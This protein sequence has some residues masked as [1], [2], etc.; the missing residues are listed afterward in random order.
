[1]R[2]RAV[3]AALALGALAGSPAAAAPALTLAQA[4]AIAS[5]STS[6]VKLADLKTNEAQG[7]WDQSRAPLLPDISAAASSVNRTYSLKALGFNP[8]AVPGETAPA[9]LVGP[10]DVV[11]ARV[12][13]SQ[14]LF[15]Y[16]S[17]VRLRAAGENVRVAGAE[18][19]QSVEGAAQGAALAYLRAV[20]AQAVADARRADLAL[21]EQ[22]LTL[23]EEQRQAGVSPGIDVTRERTQVAASRGQL[24]MA[25]NALERARVDLARALGLDP[26]V[27]F[28]LADSLSADLAASPAPSDSAAALG[29]ALERRP[30][31]A[32]ERHKLSRARAEASAIGAERLPRLDVSGDVG[33]SGDSWEG[34]TT[35][36]E[37]AIAVSMPIFDGFRREG[38]IGEQR[39]LIEESEVRTRDLSRQVAAEVRAA[40]LDLAS[41]LEQQTV[42]IEGLALAQ[43]ELDEA[44][45]RF[46]SGVAGN[47]EVITAQVSLVRARDA[48]IDA[49]YAIATA[50][51]NL[52]RAAGVCRD[53]H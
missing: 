15:D 32:V 25:Q 7:R 1:M 51:V 20:R 11:D 47:I 13:A 31:L 35:T 22:L 24:I 53:V 27:R 16:S 12:R 48:L 30:E 2:S 49:R 23:T 9:D 38:R 45:E 41:G 36:R 4:V 3:L 37:V 10:F 6:A 14:T 17:W 52:A 42:T 28:D 46:T 26:G 43:Q 18:R 21:A 34:P 19:G 44:R 33:V 8:G 5:D 39:A 29:L 50:R 40:L